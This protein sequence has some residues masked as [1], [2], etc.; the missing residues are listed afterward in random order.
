MVFSTVV[1]ACENVTV[2]QVKGCYDLLWTMLV[3]M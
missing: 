3:K 2:L 1:N